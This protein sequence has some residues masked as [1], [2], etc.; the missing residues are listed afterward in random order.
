MLGPNIQGIPEGFAQRFECTFIRTDYATVVS[1]THQLP[2]RDDRD[3]QLVDVCR[4]LDE[5]T[6]IYC[7]SPARA[8]SVVRLLLESQVTEQ[9]DA[10]QSAVKWLAREYHEEW[11][12]TRGLEAG[13]GL[14]HGRVPRSIAEFMVRIFNEGLL[15]FLVCT[16]TLI[17]GV[18]TKAKNVV[19]FDNKIA[20]KKFDYFT[21]NNIRGR[22]GRMF[23]HFVGRAYLFNEP[24][25]PDLPFVDIPMYTQDTSV[26]DSLLIQIDESD[27]TDRAKEKLTPIF[28]Q[29]SLGLEIIRHNIGISPSGQVSLAREIE[30][31][32]HY[33]DSILGWYG[34]PAYEQLEGV[35]DLI[36]S[37][38]LPRQG[39]FGGVASARQLAY[40]IHQLRK[41]KRVKALIRE[42]M[43]RGA[44]D[45][46]LA[47]EGVLEFI[48][49]W[50]CFHFPRYLGALDR[51][52]KEVAVRLGR[53]A[54]DYGVFGGQVENLFVDP[55]LV[56]LEE[57]GIP[58][59]LS[60]K[61]QHFLR[62][63]G[64]LDGVLNRIRTLDIGGLDLDEF[65]AQLLEDALS[66]L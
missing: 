49:Y 36:W 54:G 66:D 25:D 23:Q 31:K 59:Q 22:S 19:I 38:L 46:N 6:L 12:L 53:R 4:Q 63:D 60:L 26:D 2:I 32:P 29:S 14:H 52:Q 40:R 45:P 50:A 47:V 44:S 10:G 43:I 61:I 15:R 30:S 3:A 20:R 11:L 21:F 35:C 55:T 57:Y 37:H 8:N 62:P 28:Q 5:P 42:E 33:Y 58:L 16:S 1:E 48:R 17:E 65:E 56:A 24:P 7:A 13:I 27:L 64:D 34:N 39:R 9:Q 18:N 41:H 51:I